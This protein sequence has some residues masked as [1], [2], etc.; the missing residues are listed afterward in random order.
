MIREK[1]LNIAPDKTR[2][3]STATVKMVK[4]FEAKLGPHTKNNVYRETFEELYD[5]S[6]AGIYK[7]AE[8][9]SG[10]IFYG[11]LPNITFF[12]TNIAN[13]WE[14]GSRIQNK[15]LNLALF[16]KRSFTICVVMQLWLNRSMYI[17]TIISNGAHEKP[18]LI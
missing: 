5:L 6:D 18:H 9:P 11:L 4:D 7:I 16:R 13:I 3:N 17:K 8:R 12:N 14:G 15:L 10:V 2:N 1:I